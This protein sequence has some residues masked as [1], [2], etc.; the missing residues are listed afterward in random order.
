[1]RPDIAPKASAPKTPLEYEEFDSQLELSCR[2]C[3]KKGKFSV[4]RIF[5]DPA[6]MLKVHAK[7]ASYEEA[8]YFSGHFCCKKCG[9]GG[10]WD[11][12]PRT[13]L[14]LTALMVLAHG[15]KSVLPIHYG[16]LHLFDG[17]PCHSG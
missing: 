3:G 11:L 10:P 17:T 9:L 4:G 6:T 14:R 8:V 2:N 12:P 13:Q 5:V 7:E 15:Q 16:A 1:M